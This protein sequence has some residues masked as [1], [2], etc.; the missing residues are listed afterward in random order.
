MYLHA[1]FNS[2]NCIG[3]GRTLDGWLGLA[4]RWRFGNVDVCFICRWSGVLCRG[5]SPRGC[6]ARGSHPV[7][8]LMYL[9]AFNVFQLLELL[10]LHWDWQDTGWLVGTGRTL[11]VW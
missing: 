3:T 5:R 4:G 8:A 2:I 7:S 11:E 9:C 6:A 1:R 10:Q